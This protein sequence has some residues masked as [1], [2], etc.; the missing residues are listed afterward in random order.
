MKRLALTLALLALAVAPSLIA[1]EPPKFGENVEVNV[2]LIDAVVTDRGGHQ[3]LGLD[4]SD[5]AVKENGVEK[6]ID[7]VDYS[8]NRKLLNTP[9][10]KAPFKVEQVHEE[11]YFIFFFD[12]P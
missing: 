3:I 11:R 8:T 6:T 7:S 5:F 10:E 1:Q 9:E 2:V 4:K 12:K